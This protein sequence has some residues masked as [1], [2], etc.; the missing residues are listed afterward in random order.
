[1]ISFW[2]MEKNENILLSSSLGLNEKQVE[3][4]QSLTRGERLV[5]FINNRNGSDAM[6][7]LSVKKEKVKEEIK[8]GTDTRT[9]EPNIS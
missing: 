6:L 1:M 3:F 8:N 5:L 7:K 9:E 2:R 4:L